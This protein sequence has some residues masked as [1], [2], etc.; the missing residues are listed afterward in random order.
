LGLA[1]NSFCYNDIDFLLCLKSGREN[2]VII[3]EINSYVPALLIACLSLFAA[4]L[5][6]VYRLF[7]ACLLGGLWTSFV[8][9]RPSQTCTEGDKDDSLAQKLLVISI[10][11]DSL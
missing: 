11:Y 7:A 9:I 10:L 6:L 2:S 4:F 8:T 1:D 3:S 5:Q